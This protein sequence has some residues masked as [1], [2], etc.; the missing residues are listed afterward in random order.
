MAVR[1]ACATITMRALSMLQRTDQVPLPGR[2]SS[3]ARPHAQFGRTVGLGVTEHPW[4][5][6]HRSGLA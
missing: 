4:G 5:G 3:Q 1:Y 2:P 6:I